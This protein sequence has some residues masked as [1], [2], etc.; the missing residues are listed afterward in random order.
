[1]VAFELNGLTEVTSSHYLSRDSHFARS[2]IENTSTYSSRVLLFHIVSL[3]TN[4]SL[5]KITSFLWYS[6]FSCNGKNVKISLS[7]S[8]SELKSH[9]NSWDYSICVADVYI[10]EAKLNRLCK[11][12]LG[13][14][15]YLHSMQMD[16]S[17]TSLV[18]FSVVKERSPCHSCVSRW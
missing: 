3:K 13:A 2:I 17:V 9:S 16:S 1:M 7:L 18:R 14:E 15:D 4:L 8:L 6:H 10:K 11:F 5:A 12:Y